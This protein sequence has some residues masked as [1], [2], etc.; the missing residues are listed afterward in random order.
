[1]TPFLATWYWKPTGNTLLLDP[2]LLKKTGIF[3]LVSSELI[4]TI[5]GGYFVGSLVDEK[6]HTAPIFV[7][8][9]CT[10]G[11]SYS[12]WRILRVSKQWLKK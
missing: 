7:M 12:V 10:A 3:A 4:A 11:L 6:L 5:G 2:E 8:V 1:L 9:L